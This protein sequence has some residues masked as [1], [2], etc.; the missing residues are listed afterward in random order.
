LKLPIEI[1]GNIIAFVELF[2][3][4]LKFAKILSHY[5]GT[6]GM[7]T[8][9]VEANP[10]MLHNGE[11]MGCIFKSAAFR[12]DTHLPALLPEHNDYGNETGTARSYQGLIRK[13]KKQKDSTG[14]N[15]LRA[16]QRKKTFKHRRSTILQSRA[17]RLGKD[18]PIRQA[19]RRIGLLLSDNRTYDQVLSNTAPQSE[20]FMLIKQCRRED[21]EIAVKE[22]YKVVRNT[23][24]AVLNDRTTMF[25][26]CRGCLESVPYG[27]EPSL[28]LCKR[29]IVF[30]C[31]QPSPG[32]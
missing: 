32:M 22:R 29:C 4:Q 23:F 27:N 15:I 18:R 7:T 6:N 2:S 13:A 25:S 21:E 20:I 10:D 26:T 3:D 14:E 24:D 31:T 8:I 19:K 30:Y 1:H 12:G 17:H 11:L 9:L 5:Y 28:R 16:I